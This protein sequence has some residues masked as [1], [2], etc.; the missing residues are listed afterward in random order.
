MGSPVYSS[1]GPCQGCLLHLENPWVGRE[2]WYYLVLEADPCLPEIHWTVEYR[3]L[4]P[5]SREQRGLEP[6]GPVIGGLDQSQWGKPVGKCQAPV[7]KVVYLLQYRHS[8]PPWR[9]PL[10]RLWQ[11]VAVSS[12]STFSL[13]VSGGWG[14]WSIAAMRHMSVSKIHFCNFSMFIHL[15]RQRGSEVLASSLLAELC[16]SCSCLKSQN[17]SALCW[18][19]RMA[20]PAVS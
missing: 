19:L 20:S 8:H 7:E 2:T 18:R 3:F 14:W 5:A 4:W 11:I 13:L 10:P 15:E 12:L 1:M 16:H 6:G 9:C 17:Y